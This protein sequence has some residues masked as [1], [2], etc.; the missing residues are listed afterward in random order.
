ML[1]LGI[2]LFAIGII[3]CWA[4]RPQTP[5]KSDYRAYWERGYRYGKTGGNYSIED[6]DKVNQL[7]EEDI[8]LL[9]SNG[10]YFSE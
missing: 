2:L 8:Q 1:D 3:F 6:E 10:V 5:K 4:L 7:F 9:K